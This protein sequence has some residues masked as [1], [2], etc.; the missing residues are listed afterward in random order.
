MSEEELA[1]ATMRKES[2]HFDI[3]GRDDT[4]EI[5]PQDPPFK[6]KYV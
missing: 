1:V 2:I 4:V 5:C 6:V 3:D